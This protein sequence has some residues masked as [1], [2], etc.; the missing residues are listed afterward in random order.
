MRNAFVDEINQ[1]LVDRYGKLLDGRPH[2][3][4]V[5]SDDE[6]EIR[7][8][9]INVFYGKIFLY[10]KT[11][12]QQVK[13]YSYLPE[14]FILEMW[15]NSVPCK[16]MPNPNGYEPIYVFEDSKGN[17]LPVVWRVIELICYLTMNPN[18]SDKIK[19]DIEATQMK[20][21]QD[22][23]KYFE[24]LFSENS[25][26]ELHKRHFGERISNAGVISHVN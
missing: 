20:I 1:R 7:V 9:D 21:E 26:Y 22:D 18:S 10:T 24:D 17:A 12:A 16:E 23:I 2:F 14:R 19:S 11:G 3:R 15:Q 4:I 13:K 8:G 6:Y 5:F 25:S